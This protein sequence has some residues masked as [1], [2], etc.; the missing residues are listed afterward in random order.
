MSKPRFSV[1]SLIVS[2]LEEYL[3]SERNENRIPLAGQISHFN[4]TREGTTARKK[5]VPAKREALHTR[6]EQIHR[7]F[8]NGQAAC[9]PREVRQD[10]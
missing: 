10:G 4:M 5:F 2:R 7:R 1:P 6:C 3:S 8:G 9:S